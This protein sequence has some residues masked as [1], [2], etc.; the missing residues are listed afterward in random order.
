[1]LELVVGYPGGGGG[2]KGE[3]ERRCPFHR[4]RRL[5]GKQHS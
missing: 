3:R 1:M 2:S 5:I 4:V